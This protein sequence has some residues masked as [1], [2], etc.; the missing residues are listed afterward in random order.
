MADVLTSCALA[1][2]GIGL[3]Q[4]LYRVAQYYDRLVTLDIT[5]EPGM[6]RQSLAGALCRQQDWPQ[7]RRRYAPEPRFLPQ[8]MGGIIAAAY[9]ILYVRLGINIFALALAWAL[10]ALL[11][12]ALI[13]A[14]TG[15]LPDSLTIPLLWA[16]L[17]LAWSGEGLVSLEHAFACTIAVYLALWLFC[18]TY[19][20]LRRRQGLGGGDVKLMAAIGAWL[21]WPD[22]LWVLVGGSM[23]GLLLALLLQRGLRMTDAQPF[24]PP[25]IL[26]ALAI[27]AVR[28]GEIAG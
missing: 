28:I 15:L 16:G 12:L 10:A 14:R 11:L 3:G 26:A 7:D 6:L 9:V 20:M 27:V 24:G 1:C 17:A 13:D 8:V 23:L 19:Q 21:G 18:E 22:T 4:Y 5:P 2:L 25:L